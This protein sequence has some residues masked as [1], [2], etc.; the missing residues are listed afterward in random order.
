MKVVRKM[1][2]EIEE[3]IVDDELK[4]DDIELDV[5]KENPELEDLIITP[6]AQEQ[7]FK[8]SKY[9][10]DN[11]KIK[12]IES[13]EIRIVP[14]T[15]EQTKTGIF[16]KITVAGDSDLIS[17]NIKKG[18]EIFG[19]IGTANISDLKITN[20]KY[21]FAFDARI[22]QLNEILNLCE[23][24]TDTSNMFYYGGITEIDLSNFDTSNVTN[25][26]NMFSKS[27]RLKKI[28]KV[29]ASSCISI[30]YPFD[31]CSQLSDFGGFINLGKGYSQ[32]T[33]NFN[34]Y[35]LN[36]SNNKNLTYESL[37]NII[38]NLYDL[39]LTYNVAGGGTLYTQ[40]LNLGET[41]LAKLT[42]EEIAIA[43]N[44]GWNVT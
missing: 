27:N 8:S 19:V 38:N 14:R 37:M 43:T 41:N 30:S 32:K 36:V 42:E 35:K 25:M 1:E 6:S 12:A 16:N 20:C 7:T 2:L 23:N 31:G 3:I 10:Y 9:G 33:S 17:D 29:D 5:I 39:N 28:S 40:I 22:E 15:E 26:S 21:L 11:V 34:S 44:K 18:A 4:I 24:V 13:E